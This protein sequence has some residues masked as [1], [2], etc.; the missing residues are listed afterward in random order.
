[1]RWFSI[2]ADATDRVSIIN[3]SVGAEDIIVMRENGADN[4]VVAH[5]R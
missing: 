4:R 1:M 2:V 5:G 3:V